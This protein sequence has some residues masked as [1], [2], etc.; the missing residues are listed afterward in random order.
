MIIILKSVGCAYD[1]ETKIIY[2]MYNETAQRLYNKL[3]D[4]DSA[5]HI[6]DVDN[7][8]VDTLSDEDVI[9]INE[10]AEERN[11]PKPYSRKEIRVYA[12][13]VSE[14]GS[15]DMPLGEWQ[16]C[17]D[18]LF[19]DIAERQGHIWTLQ[20]FQ[21]AYNKEEIGHLYDFYIRF[22]EVELFEL[23]ETN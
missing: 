1:T 12:I 9:L 19:M 20:G 23:I 11:T 17:S 8:W 16:S 5:V 6:D 4:E 10:S 18:E 22:I 13:N 3:Y 7:H 14:E 21:E 15:E 2:A